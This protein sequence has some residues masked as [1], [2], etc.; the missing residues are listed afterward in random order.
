MANYEFLT[1]W[2]L[3][4]P[5]EQVFDVLHDSK[6]YPDWWKGVQSV[7]VLEEGDETGAGEL[8]RFSWRSV[9][10]YTLE[11]DLR[12]TRVERP[13]LMEGNAT[14]ELEGVGIWRLFEGPPGTAVIYDWRVR[15]TKA[16]M[17]AFGP[18]ARP[19]FAWNHDLV[20]RQGGHG[21]AKRLNAT[22]A[23]HD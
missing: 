9:L 20:M 7:E 22:L 11:F 13:H 4:A 5:V 1:T 19:A 16:W 14:G 10:P 15:T 12:L 23:A 3:D 21:L 2:L 17:N 6:S 18:V 8:D